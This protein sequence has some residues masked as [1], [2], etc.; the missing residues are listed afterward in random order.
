MK[1]I[2]IIFILLCLSSC[3]AK[4]QVNDTEHQ[5]KGINNQ[6]FYE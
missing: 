3:I 5:W 4:K 2:I 1:N 6:K